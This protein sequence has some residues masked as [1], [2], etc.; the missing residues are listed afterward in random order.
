MKLVIAL[1]A[2]TALAALYVSSGVEQLPESH[3]RSEF[4]SFVSEF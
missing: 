1:I 4:M 2:V 3:Y